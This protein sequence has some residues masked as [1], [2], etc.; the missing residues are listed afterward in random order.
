MG[1]PLFDARTKELQGAMQGYSPAGQ[2]GGFEAA[3]MTDVES[4]M[5]LSGGYS[6]N[7]QAASTS[8][9][10]KIAMA[11]SFGEAFKIARNTY[12]P[13][14]VFEYNGK[15][16]TTKLHEEVEAEKAKNI[17][18]KVIA[19][20]IQNQGLVQPVRKGEFDLQSI[21][22]PGTN[23][24]NSPAIDTPA[25]ASGFPEHQ[26]PWMM[27]RMPSGMTR[28]AE[29]RIKYQNPDDQHPF[30]NALKNLF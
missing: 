8:P 26:K 19:E 7:T 9:E 30:L 3:S 17:A 28:L 21:F 29:E 1:N 23:M 2:S 11:K 25:Q 16:F 12:G 14:A 27:D 6:P 4:S 18:H 22:N 24:G 15:K 5:D 10:A 20:K 13:N